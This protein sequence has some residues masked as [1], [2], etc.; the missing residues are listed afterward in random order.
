MAETDT[1]RSRRGCA[2]CDNRNSKS[3]VCA[4]CDERYTDEFG[5]NWQQ[6]EW[7]QALIRH[8]KNR[9]N[10][11]DRDRYRGHVSFDQSVNDETLS[12]GGPLPMGFTVNASIHEMT[13]YLEPDEISL[14]RVELSY[15]DRD[16]QQKADKLAAAIGFPVSSVAYRKRKE[17][18][19]KKIQDRESTRLKLTPNE[20]GLINIEVSA[21]LAEQTHNR[22]TVATVS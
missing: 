9:R 20:C 15:H 5:E 19:V 3:Y 22:V 4:E 16:S 10:Q 13:A 18:L 8:E 14:L 7:A 1:L 17:R 12:T 21:Y 11:L 6:T 2:F